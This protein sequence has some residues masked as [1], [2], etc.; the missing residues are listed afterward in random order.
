[1]ETGMNASSHLAR[2]TPSTNLEP[3]GSYPGRRGTEVEVVDARGMAGDYAASLR[4]KHAPSE[5]GGRFPSSY[6][7]SR[8]CRPWAFHPPYA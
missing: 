2:E 6:W 5:R 7:R 4:E 8:T 1:M 3:E